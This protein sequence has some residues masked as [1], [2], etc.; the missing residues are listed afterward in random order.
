M[1]GSR[2]SRVVLL[3]GLALG[4]AACGGGGGDTSTGPSGP[5]TAYLFQHNARFNDGVT[6]R[7]PTLPIRVFTNNIAS[8]DEVR[9]WTQVTGGLVTFT[10]VGSAS[11]ADITFRFGAGD[12]LCGVTTVEF[13]S[14]GRIVNS[15]VR[16]VKE[17]FRG[18]QCVRTVTHETGHAIGFLDHTADGGLMDPD[19]GNGEITAP[20]ARFFIDLYTLAPGTFVGS[21]LKPQATLRRSGGRYVVTIVDPVRR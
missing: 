11:Q 6:T 1:I 4:L 8:P 19:G 20:V 15:D 9:V 5:D 13:E 2:R 18:P 16:V 3:V 12:D 7:W 17:I 10:F 14:D 21:A